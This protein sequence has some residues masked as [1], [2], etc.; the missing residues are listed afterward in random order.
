MLG[1][2]FGRAPSREQ[3]PATR[4][5]AIPQGI[6]IYAVGDVHGRA[7]LVRQLSEQVS[8]DVAGFKG[9]AVTVFLGDYVD[10]GP[11]SRQVIDLLAA[12]DW[13]TAI[14]P[15]KGNHE[16]AF[17]DFVEHPDAWSEWQGYGALPTLASYGV[18]V[19]DL[20][21]GAPAVQALARIHDELLAAMPAE[22]VTF[23]NG[24]R[25]Q[26]AAGDYFFCHAGIRPGIPFEQQSPDDLISIREPFLSSTA[27]F[28]KIVVHGHTPQETPQIRP[29]R[30]GIDTG[31]YATGCLTALILEGETR[32]WLSTGRGPKTRRVDP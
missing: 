32:A 4:G 13:P 15:L 25:D 26:T 17:M 21:T 8:A 10:R 19:R 5:P 1:R 14:L 3:S 31:A 30:I 2:L 9:P 22:H 7:D 20:M 29:N 16:R 12:R 6:R 24:L 28:E 23:F 18:N 11:H 27:Q